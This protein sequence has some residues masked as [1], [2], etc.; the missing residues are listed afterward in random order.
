MDQLRA[1]AWEVNDLQ[2]E[3]IELGNAVL[4]E[5]SSF[6]SWI[7]SHLFGRRLPFRELTVAS[8]ALARKFEDQEHR[9]RSFE[10]SGLVPQRYSEFFALLLE[11]TSALKQSALVLEQN[12]RVALEG[13][14]GIR[15]VSL[16]EI[17]EG[18]RHYNLSMLQ[19]MEVAARLQPHMNML[20][21]EVGT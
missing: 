9:L 1:L 6:G 20:F 17:Q 14:E 12:Q 18:A 2:T 15:E 4:K 16:S 7:R 21:S 10:S 11:F 13:A 5:T 8:S 19:Y 3:L